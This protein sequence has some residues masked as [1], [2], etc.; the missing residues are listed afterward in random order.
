MR[1]KI[2]WLSL[3]LAGLNVGCRKSQIEPPPKADVLFAFHFVGT[4]RLSSETNAT[5]WTAMAALPATRELEEQIL[6]KLARA[7]HQLLQNRLVGDDNDYA[8]VLRPLLRDLIRAESFAE[9]RAVSNGTPEFVLAVRLGD[10]R[11]QAWKTNLAVVLSSWSSVKPRGILGKYFD[12]WELKKHHAPNS[13]KFVRARQWVVLGWGQDETPLLTKFLEQIREGGQPKLPD[14]QAWLEASVDWPRLQPLLPTSLPAGLPQ[15][16]LTL[17]GL[18]EDLRTKME[19]V[20]PKPIDWSPE[21]WRIP[22]NTIREPLIS[23][24]AGQGIAPFLSRQP[25]F[26]DLKIEPVPNQFYLWAL[27]DIPFQTFLAV[28]S[29]DTTNLLKHLEPQLTER[30][31]TN[32]QKRSLGEIRWSTNMGALAWQGLPFIVPFIQPVVET[33]GEF[34]FAGLFPNGP[35]AKPPPPELLAQFSGRTNLVY[36]DW[37][38]TQARLTQWRNLSQLFRIIANRPQIDSDAPVWKWFDVVVTNLGNTATEI[39]V[40]GPAQMSLARKSPVGLTAF[41]LVALANWLESPNFPLG[42][43]SLPKRPDSQRTVPAPTASDAE[44]GRQH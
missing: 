16:H 29:Q 31:K 2:V 30:F 23:F 14:A 5:R 6:W 32:L 34:L 13:I 41:E 40:T 38:I 21:P 25:V 3:L 15:M 10:E 20:F 43:Y 18:E 9:M 24:T 17:T 12:G 1:S 22:T 33:N 44:T 19:L 39:T 4:E 7:P 11:A 37:E 28:P 42:G 26:Q 36:Y 35:A 8:D 27:G